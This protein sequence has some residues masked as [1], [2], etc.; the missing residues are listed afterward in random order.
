M[1]DSAVNIQVLGQCHRWMNLC[2]TRVETFEMNGVTG[3]NG[4]PWWKCT[5]PTRMCGPSR[6][7]VFSHKFSLDLDR[8]PYQ[9]GK[10]FSTR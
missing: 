4:E 8:L 2:P 9:N 7:A 1:N 10:H 6:K 3:L 5:V